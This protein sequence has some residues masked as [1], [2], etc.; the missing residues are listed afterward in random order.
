MTINI[1]F[2]RTLLFTS[3]SVFSAILCAQSVLVL[4]GAHEPGTDIEGRALSAT[5][6]LDWEL[7]T[8]ELVFGQ[9]SSRELNEQTTAIGYMYNQKLEMNSG[10]LEHELRVDAQ[11]SGHNYEDY[12]LHFSEDTVIAEVDSTHAEN[13]VLNRKPMIVGYNTNDDHAGFWLYQSPPWSADVFEHAQTGGALY[14]YHSEPFERLQFKFSQKAIIGTVNETAPFTLEYPSEIDNKGKVTRWST[15][16]VKHDKTLGM[17]RNGNVIWHMPSDWVRATTHDGSGVSYGGGPYFG[18]TYLRDGGQLYVVRIRWHNQATRPILKDVKL[19]NS[20][21]I[22]TPKNAPAM[23]RDGRIISRWR[24]IRGFDFS[25]DHN[26]DGY[27]SPTEYKSRQNKSATARFRWES[28]V[29]P[30]GRMWNS[31]SSWALT[32]LALP[33]YQAAMQ[34][35]YQKNWPNWGLKGAYNDDTN[36][37]LGPN[38]FEVLSGGNITELGMVAGSD[39]ADALYQQQF[40]DFL[41]QLRRND[42]ASLISVNIGTANLYGRNGQNKL[43]KAASLYLR[44][45]YIFPS[46]GLSGYAGIAKFWDNAAFAHRGAKVI[47]QATTRHGRVDYFGHTKENWLNDQYAALVIYYLNSHSSLSYFNQWNSSYQYGSGNTT[48][49]NFWKSGIA[50]NIAYQPH[51]LLA[52]VL[53]APTGHIPQGYAPVSLMLSTQTP[54]PADYSVVGTTRSPTLVHYDLP[55]GSVDVKPTFTYFRYQSPEQVV[56]NGPSEMV[57]ARE[58]EHGLVLYRT[59]FFGKQRDYFS[60]PPLRIELEKEMRPVLPNGDIGQPVSVVELSGYEGLI[61]LH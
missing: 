52:H 10:W 42:P 44:E 51:H 4:P 34:R 36:K 32:H 41:S 7:Q 37:L 12:F 25:A 35:Y 1:R 43:I 54:V 30:F 20:F 53:G 24:K 27:L 22:V 14:V 33:Q 56:P 58:F 29:I 15:L 9:Y 45:H 16:A 3:A 40:A 17:T 59:D 47:F 18:S 11:Q 28:R 38:Q 13:T 49:D 50:K 39:A 60:Q 46:T 23:T 6:V 31:H 61:L 2:A 5:E 21:P 19:K 48:A 55:N 26:H 8:S 57:L